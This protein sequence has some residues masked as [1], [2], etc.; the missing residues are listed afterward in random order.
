MMLIA[1]LVLPRPPSR[2]TST[3]FARDDIH[4]GSRP[5]ST[6]AAIVAATVTASTMPSTSKDT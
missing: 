4:A 5:E 6:A 3:T 2:R 1:L